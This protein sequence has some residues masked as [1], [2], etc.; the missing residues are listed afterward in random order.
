MVLTVVP[1][2]VGSLARIF[3]DFDTQIF[4]KYFGDG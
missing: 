2:N 4:V 1:K 3:R